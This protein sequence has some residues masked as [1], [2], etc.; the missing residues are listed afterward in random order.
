MRRRLALLLAG[1]ACA[2]LG[3]CG[4]PVTGGDT[5]EV[6]VLLP[7]SAGLFVG[8]DVGVLGVPVGEIASIEPDGEHVRVVL[9]VDVERAVP[10]DAGAVVVAR[11]VATDRYL[12][13]TPVYD[14][15]ARLSDGDVIGADR[16]R[17]PVDFDAVLGALNDFAT[18]IAGSRDTTDAVRRFIESGD[19]ALRGRGEL[20]NTTITSV[21]DAVED[22]AGQRDDITAT[23]SS[24][25]TLVATVAEN[26]GTV[27]SFVRQ[28][29][30][31]SRLLAE[32]R[33]EFRTTLRALDRAVTTVADFAVRNRA[34]IVA[35]LDG[36][37]R[38]MRTILVKQRDL[39]EILEVF[40]LALQNLE[41]I[42]VDSAV[43]VRFP[44]AVLV[45][46][47]AEVRRLCDG[48]PLQLCQLIGGTDPTDRS[49]APG[50]AR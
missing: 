20:L 46:L 14:G 26:E 1:S 41:R 3:A 29:S 16:T 39:V 34:E 27:R 28:V 7:D 43:P 45:P 24:L 35:A 18:G 13:L 40:P 25:D 33:Q 15:G 36:T 6:T 2:A 32:Q 44:P 4:V 30:L 10:A 17:T 38:L 11:S 5:M 9:E 42:P 12:E 31:G 19:G 8:N 21:A 37:T 49:P 48:L 22:V 23:I 47:G 50:A